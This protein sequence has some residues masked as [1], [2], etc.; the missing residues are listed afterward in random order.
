MILSARSLSSLQSCPRRFLLESKYD[1][2]KWR[3]KALLDA[4]LRK[5]ILDISQG[6][7]VAEVAGNAVADFLQAAA[8]PGLDL[9]RGTDPYKVAVDHCAMMETVLRSAAHWRLPRLAECPPLRVNASETEWQL[10]SFQAPDESLHRF[11]TMD[12]WDEAA[13]ARERHGWAAA[14]DTA[15]TGRGMTVHAVE[16][17][18]RRAGRQSSPWCRAWRHPAMPNLKLRFANKDGSKPKGWE[19]IYLADH[20][21]L[22]RDAWVRQMEG[23][24][25]MP[26][27]VHEM[28]IPRPTEKDRA[29]TLWGIMQEARRAGV[30][31]SEHWA[32]LPLHRASC[33]GMVPCPFIPACHEGVTDLG[34][35]GL[36]VLRSRDIL[37]VA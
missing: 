28:A 3:P 20:R 23:E 35:T 15:A 10:S 30:L 1:I 22:D 13:M 6:K 14:G 21:D 32:E 9:P 16:I 29:A 12:R 18:Q 34:N 37:R 19:A 27:L 17:G 11:V 24:G 8:N 4:S 33:D 31:L 26:G 36:Y 5:G 2:L 25:I 7:P